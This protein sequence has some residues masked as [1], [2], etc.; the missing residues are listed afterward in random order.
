[1]ASLINA[2]PPLSVAPKDPNTVD[3][4]DAYTSTK[5]A[6]ADWLAAERAKS[7]AMG[8]WDEATGLPTQRGLINA[9]SQ[10]ALGTNSSS[11]IKASLPMDTASRMKRAEDMGFTI[12]AYHGGPG[13]NPYDTSA[14]GAMGTI[15]EFRLGPEGAAFFT[16]DPALAGD[17]AATRN[18]DR[19]TVYPVKI[20]SGDMITHDQADGFKSNADLMELAKKS[21][22]S[23][24]E[25]KNALD[26][27]PGGKRAPS[28]VYMVLDPSAVRSP[29]ATFDPKER[30][31]ASITASAAGLAAG[32]G[33]AATGGNADQ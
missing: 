18:A 22:A 19:S 26:N 33:A 32:V 8:Y 3:T 17:Y 12:D 1:M 30:G 7:A 24:V 28:T 15:K 20:H 21:G 2:A 9:V 11:G 10:V 16:S 23:V 25:V 4:A 5:G 6:L 27:V 31:S 13:T 14:A 29:F